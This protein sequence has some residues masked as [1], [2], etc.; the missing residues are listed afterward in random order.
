MYF[1]WNTQ[2]A[3]PCHILRRSDHQR[4][5]IKRN[6]RQNESLFVISCQAVSI[7][8]YSATD[9]GNFHFF[10]LLE[11]AHIQLVIEA[12]F[13]KQFIMLAALD[14]LTIFQHQ[15]HIRVANRG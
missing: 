10:L 2:N 6:S 3:L 11:L 9:L 1:H 12:F 8:G 7:R 4:L 14:D 5:S 13:G 15:N